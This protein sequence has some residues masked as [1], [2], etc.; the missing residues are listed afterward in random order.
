MTTYTLFLCDQFGAVQDVIDQSVISSLHYALVENEINA[1]EIVLPQL[2]PWEYFEADQLLLIQRNAGAG[3]YIEADRAFF[4]QD[5]EYYTDENNQQWI[6]LTGVDGNDLLNRRIVAYASGSAQAK[7]TDEY[8]DIIKLVASQNM[9]STATD[10]ARSL[11]SY[12]MIASDHAAA[13]QATDMEFAYKSLF[14]VAQDCVEASE[15]AGTYLAFDIS[16]MGDGKFY[17]ET[18]TQFHGIDHSRDGDDPRY[19]QIWQPRVIRRHSDERNFIY[20]GGKGE[21]DSRTIK[22]ASDS[23]YMRT[24]WSRREEFSD[25]RNSDTD[26]AIQEQANADLKKY[27]ARTN[28]EGQILEGDGFMY[29]IDFRWGDVVGIMAHG[30]AFDV[31][32]A[33]V[34][35]DMSAGVE[36]ITTMLRSE[37]D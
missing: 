24:I 21:G 23:A 5:F 29:G 4:L 25:A 32:I 35:V 28:I 2:W 20:C 33:A 8:D 1:V 17:L 7:M 9:G 11:A 26:G 31:H 10:T 6:Q 36:T 3:P 27:R 18:F 15:E 37:D 19:I 34:E 30:E 12:L 16:Y 22:T 14:T 13:P